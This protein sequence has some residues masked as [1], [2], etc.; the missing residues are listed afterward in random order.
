MLNEVLLDALNTQ[1]NKEIF[2]S[3]L[4]LSMS[5]HFE[6]NNLPGFAKWTRLQSQEEYGHAMKMF[7]FIIDRGNEVTLQ[8]IDQ[9]PVKFGTP[10]EVF[11]HIYSHE[12]VV[13]G[14]IHSLYSLALKEA[15]YPS[16]IMLQ[17]FVNEQVEEEKNSS[18][19]VEMLKMAG[20]NMSIVMMLD[21]HLGKRGG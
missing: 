15:D 13:T 6:A 21:G 20:N 3:Y 4:Y 18:Q 2:S 16:Q 14:L 5:A 1:I 9:P 7:D 8:A 12:K 17:W 19:V 11:E 10:L